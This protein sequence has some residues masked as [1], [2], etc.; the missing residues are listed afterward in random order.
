MPQTFSSLAVILNYCW[1]IT[2][3]YDLLFMLLRCSCAL[4]FS[5]LWSGTESIGFLTSREISFSSK[6]SN[7]LITGKK[8]NHAYRASNQSERMRSLWIVSKNA[9]G[10]SKVILNSAMSKMGSF[11]QQNFFAVNNLI[12]FVSHSID[13]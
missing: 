12:G 1:A 7:Y 3:C 6:I 11:F 8:I 13:Q 2:Y 10:E 9:C 5:L 4:L